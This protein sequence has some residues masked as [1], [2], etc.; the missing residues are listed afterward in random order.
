MASKCCWIPPLPWRATF[1]GFV[2]V[3]RANPKKV[4]SRYLFRWFS[5][6]RIQ[7]TVRSFGQQTTNISNLN[8]ERCLNQSLFLPSLSEQRRIA[9][10]LDRADELRAKRRAALARLDT[11]TQAIF[12]DMFGDPA[13]NPKG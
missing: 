5:S 12:L 3:L 7:A 2:S 11:L 13:T 4:E 6:G 10:I 9:A 8:I 1:G